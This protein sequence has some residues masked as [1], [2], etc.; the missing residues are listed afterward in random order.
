[1]PM[2]TRPRPHTI[3]QRRACIVSQIQQQAINFER[4]AIRYKTQLT[5]KN[6]T[7][8]RGHFGVYLHLQRLVVSQRLTRYDHGVV[9]LS[10][11]LGALGSPRAITDLGPPSAEMVKSVALA[12]RC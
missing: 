7:R 8:P 3:L 4:T 2:H 12:G 10:P 9:K 5:D 1:M 6:R 11:R